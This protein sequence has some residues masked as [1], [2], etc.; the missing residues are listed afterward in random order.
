[1]GTAEGVRYVRGRIHAPPPDG[2][3][4]KV[5]Q[6][7][8]ILDATRT[9]AHRAFVESEPAALLAAHRTLYR[10]YE[11]NVR[12]PA[13]AVLVNQFDPTLVQIRRI[14]ERAW[15]RRERSRRTFSQGG[16]SGPEQF[17][18][19]HRRLLTEHR[20]RAHPLSDYLA[21]EATR[22]D[23]A[24]YVTWTGL[25]NLRF[26][27]LIALALVGLNSDRMRREIVDSL[28]DEN[29]APGTK[30]HTKWRVSLLRINPSLAWLSRLDEQVRRYTA[31]SRTAP[32]PECEAS[33]MLMGGPW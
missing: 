7:P 33:L 6:H 20:V 21:D 28:V 23:L 9:V 27:D 26:F 12:T 18:A 3:D 29:A 4:N 17:L 30:G 24:R 2:L 1:M 11:Q 32:S 19:A 25:L 5:R 14:L 13:Q 22:A 16:L 10:L 15:E 8:R 31:R